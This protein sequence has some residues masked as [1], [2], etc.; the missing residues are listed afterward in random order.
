MGLNCGCGYGCP[1]LTG[2]ADFEFL[3]YR[4]ILKACC[5]VVFVWMQLDQSID[6]PRNSG[7][8]C[9]FVIGLRLFLDRM[10]WFDIDHYGIDC[11]TADF[12]SLGVVLG[13]G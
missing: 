4:L 8:S 6:C 1:R 9:L 7:S 12:S 10:G 2:G 11:C 3:C 13:A 5:F